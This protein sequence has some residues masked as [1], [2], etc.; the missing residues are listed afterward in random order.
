MNKQEFTIRDYDG[1]NPN[2][3]ALAY[4]E[5][6]KLLKIDFLCEWGNK[7]KEELRQHLDWKVI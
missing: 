4:H 1:E 3:E 5:R 2:E 6:L 7:K